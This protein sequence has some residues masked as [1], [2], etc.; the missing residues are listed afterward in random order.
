[1]FVHDYAAVAA[2]MLVGGIAWLMLLS[3]FNASVQASVPAWVRGRALSVY[4]LVTFGALGGGSALW[5]AIADEV[6]IPAALGASA[7]GM[8]VGLVATLRFRIAQ[9]T[10]AGLEPSLHWPAPRADAPIDPEEGPVVVTIEYRVP[11]G[12]FEA[13]AQA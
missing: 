6:G 10:L 7:V 4:L 5:G 8:V 9:P 12:R 2:A 3:S 13:F 1:A 11:E